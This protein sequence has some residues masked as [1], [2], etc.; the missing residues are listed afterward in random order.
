MRIEEYRWLPNQPLA[1]NY[2][3]SFDSVS[4]LYAYNPHDP[5]KFAARAEWLDRDIRPSLDRDKLASV[6]RDYNQAVGNAPEAMEA[7]DALQDPRTLV[8]VGGQQAGLFTGPLLVIFKAI[9]VLQTARFASEQLNRRVVPVFWIAGED[10]DLDEVNHV[11]VLTDS[12]SIHKIKLATVPE[13]RGP[14]SSVSISQEEWQEV[15]EQLEASLMNTEFKAGLMEQ[16]KEACLNASSLTDSFARLMAQWFGSYGLVLIDSADPSWRRLEA[17]MFKELAEKER[18]LNTVLL[19]SQTE[20]QNLGFTPQAEVRSEQAN[21]FFLH[22]GERLLLQVDNDG[23]YTDKR[24]ELKLTREELITIASTQPEKLSN[25]V[26]TRPLMQDY[27]LP[28]L[29]V[30]LGT[31]EIAYWGVLKNAFE[32]VGMQMPI[33]EPRMEFSLVEGT[34]QKQMGKYGLTFE[35][36]I[37]HF[38]RK[39]QEWLDSQGSLQLSETFAE[40]KLQFADLYKPVIDRVG[41]INPGMRKLGETNMAK[42]VEQIEFLESR[43]N[44]AF[45]SQFES[46]LRHWERL[47]VSLYP[48]AKPQERVFNALA[49]FVKYGDGWLKELITAPMQPNGS[50]RIVSF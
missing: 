1:R 28:V 12:L 49:Y 9:T 43:A 50:H 33:L 44:E 25:N 31:S 46:A 5:N 26:M 19:T 30:V 42:I 17:P 23:N 4:S 18:E 22:N 34:L 8:V 36:I 37:L 47:R 40:I 6:L 48:Q 38:D 41:T 16:V 13:K 15:L 20:L 35:D 21:L 11:N 27:M 10:H 3:E 2:I 39:K 29:S 7:I 32:H 24:G 45:E 14:V